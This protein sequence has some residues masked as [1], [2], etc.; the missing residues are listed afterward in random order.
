MVDTPFSKYPAAGAITGEEITLI[1]Q[2]SASIRISGTTISALAS[3][4]SFND[5]GSGF[6]AAGFAVDDYVHVVGFTGNVANNIF[7]AKITALTAGK[8]T[9]GGADGN[10]IVD[11]AAGET[12]TIAKWVSARA[13]AAGRSLIAETVTSGSATNVQFASIPA[14]FRD[15]EVRVRG[16]GAAAAVNVAVRMRMNGDTGSNYDGETQQANNT[17]NTNFAN[18]GVSSAYIGNLAAASATSG[19]ADAVKAE[20]F[21][22]RG[23]TF[24]KAGLYI[25]SLKT[26][27]AAANMFNEC[28]SFWWRSA[29]AIT[30]LDVFLSSGAFVDGSVVSLYGKM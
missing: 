12:V 21:D 10:V 19:V 30:Q 17:T 1:S 3:D 7:S 29:S 23:T 11:D 15:L 8:M 26:G 27:T 14:K 28:G 24:Q 4:N 22:Y 16:R 25:A 5:S 20:I 2:L 6:V 13:D 18:A 9:I